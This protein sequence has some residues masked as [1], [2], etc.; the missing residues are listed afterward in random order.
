MSRALVSRQG[1]LQVVIQGKDKDP[2]AGFG[3]DVGMQ[4]E[5]FCASDIANDLV[6]KGA[7]SVDQSCAHFFDQFFAVD[8]LCQLFFRRGQN[9]FETND[10]Q[11]FDDKDARFLWAAAHVVDLEL[12][13]GLTDLG[14]NFAFCLHRYIAPAFGP[15][16]LRE[17]QAATKEGDLINS[18]AL[19]VSD[20]GL[21]RQYLYP[22]Q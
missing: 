22:I 18:L 6:Q 21:L 3:A 13:D 7:R 9:A 16:V 5:N 12:D 14:F 17:A 19:T 10:N 15:G 4:I 20:N 11:V 2:F 1:F 8:R